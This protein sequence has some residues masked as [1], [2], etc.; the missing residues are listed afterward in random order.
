M[1]ILF[2]AEGCL[3]WFGQSNSRTIRW[4]IAPPLVARRRRRYANRSAMKG[5]RG[6]LRSFA[7]EANARRSRGPLPDAME[8]RIRFRAGIEQPRIAKGPP[9]PGAPL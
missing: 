3:D 5:L 8:R 6:V 9:R 7:V 2:A 4:G 1:S